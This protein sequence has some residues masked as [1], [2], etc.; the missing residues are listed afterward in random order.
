MRPALSWSPVRTLC[1]VRLPSPLGWLGYRLNKGMAGQ[2]P[3]G[4][5]GTSKRPGGNSTRRVKLQ[6]ST[7]DYG[8]VGAIRSIPRTARAVG[9]N[10]Q[11]RRW[12]ATAATISALAQ[13]VEVTDREVRIIGSKSN[14][15]QTLTAG[16]GA[17]PATPGVRSPVLR[18]R[19]GRD[20][21]P[22]YL[23]V[24][25]LSRRAQSTALAPIRNEP[26]SLVSIDRSCNPFVT[27]GT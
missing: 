11:D 21:N 6:S 2:W 14:L 3:S 17:K 16:A 18:W 13:R 25:T 19:M 15:L 9:W 10:E 1:F 27:L 7:T 5:R 26:R 20:S 22:R 8:A 23:A 12:G 4:P 24:H